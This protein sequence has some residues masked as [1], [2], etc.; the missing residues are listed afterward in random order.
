M[1]RDAALE[2]STVFSWNAAVLAEKGI[3]VA[4]GSGVED[5]VPKTRVM[6]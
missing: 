6:R 4:I 1:Q 5:Y 2:T 3:S